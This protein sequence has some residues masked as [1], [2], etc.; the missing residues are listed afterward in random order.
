MIPINS[1][2]A[3]WQRY[4][5]SCR[6]TNTTESRDVDIL[7]FDNAL[8]LA[9]AVIAARVAWGLRKQQ[10]MWRWIVAYW[11]ILTIRNLGVLI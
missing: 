9:L 7:G 3:R 6:C 8:L 11:V 1:G 2:N 10:N 5:I 4:S